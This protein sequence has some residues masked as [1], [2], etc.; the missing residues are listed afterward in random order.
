M[1][2]RLLAE[3]CRAKRG[4]VGRGVRGVGGGHQPGNRPRRGGISALIGGTA[5]FGGVGCDDVGLR[6]QPFRTHHRVG[7]GWAAPTCWYRVG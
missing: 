6:K 1:Q 3:R 2:D 7:S 5:L 4:C